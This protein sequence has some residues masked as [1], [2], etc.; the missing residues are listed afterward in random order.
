MLTLGLVALISVPVF[1]TVTHLPPYMG[2]M[3][4]LG[5]LWVVAELISHTMDDATHSSTGVLAVLQKVDMSSIL[6]F[7][8]ILLAV[9]SLGAMGTLRQAAMSLDQIPPQS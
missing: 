8:G 7:L 3:L 9:G 2:M 5:I 4:S 1:K 6:F